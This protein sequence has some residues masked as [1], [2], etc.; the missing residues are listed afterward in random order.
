MK[1]LVDLDCVKLSNFSNLKNKVRYLYA[2]IPQGIVAKTFL[3]NFFL[4]NKLDEYNTLK[5]HLK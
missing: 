5:E 4:K 3:V 1:V 2:L